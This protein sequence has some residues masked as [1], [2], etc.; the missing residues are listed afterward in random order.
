MFKKYIPNILT[1]INLSF[2]VI[3]II[4]I[5]NKNFLG[6]AI[7]I[8]LAA[9]VD[10]YDGRIA[11]FLNVHSE[12][13]KELDSLA[14]LISFGVTPAILLFV[15][16]IPSDQILRVT[17]VI[18]ILTY[19]ICGCYRLA[20]YNVSEFDGTFTGIPITLAGS[21]LALFSLFVPSTR[22]SIVLSNILIIVLAYLMVSKLKLKKI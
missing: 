7:L 18:F 1:F 19:I 6:A 10:R 5:L 11:R 2:G 12:L 8:I 4:E 3:S 9:L 22:I 14:D 15:K 16:Y 17:G 20:K 21:F 13:G